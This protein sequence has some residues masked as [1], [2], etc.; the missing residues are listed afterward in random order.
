METDSTCGCE[1]WRRL[2]LTRSDVILSDV[3]DH[4]QPIDV[5][6]LEVLSP[7]VGV[8]DERSHLERVE[9]LADVWFE[10][11]AT[12]IVR[13]LTDVL[14]A[15]HG[16]SAPKCRLADGKLFSTASILGRVG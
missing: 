5:Q 9:L 14:Q 7:Y 13:V 1:I 2:R 8:V 3:L 15:S 4:E 10:H 6:S 12:L 11:C 16:V